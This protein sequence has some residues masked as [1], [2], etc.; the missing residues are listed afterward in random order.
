MISQ[1]PKK[2]KARMLRVPSSL[3]VNVLDGNGVPGWDSVYGIVA[4]IFH[5]YKL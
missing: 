5:Q 4:D 1:H 2:I 3:A